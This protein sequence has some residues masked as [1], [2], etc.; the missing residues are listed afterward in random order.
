M[1][2]TE[3]EITN[4]ANRIANFL[5]SLPCGSSTCERKIAKR[6]L[7]LNSGVF[8]AQGRPYNFNIK[9]IGVGMVK[10]SLSPA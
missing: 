10:V 2:K 8:L 1:K 9:N 4:E 7:E 5:A 3:Q 6:I